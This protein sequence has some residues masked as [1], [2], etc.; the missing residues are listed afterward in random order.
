MPRLTE[1]K[2][3][4]TTASARHRGIDTGSLFQC[5]PVLIDDLQARGMDERLYDTYMG[6]GKCVVKDNEGKIG[7]IYDGQVTHDLTASGFSAEWRGN[8]RNK[9]WEI[10]TFERLIDKV[11]VG[12]NLEVLQKRE[13]F[14]VCKRATVD[15]AFVLMHLQK[16]A[17]YLRFP[18]NLVFRVHGV[19]GF[20]NETL[21]LISKCFKEAARVMAERY[22]NNP[23]KKPKFLIAITN[24]VRWGSILFKLFVEAPLRPFLNAADA[25]LAPIG[26][27][28]KNLRR[29]NDELGAA[30][31]FAVEN[32][33]ALYIKP[34][35]L[36]GGGRGVMRIEFRSADGTAM[37]GIQTN[38]EKLLGD[39][40]M[41]FRGTR[42]EN[43]AVLVNVEGENAPEAYE[44]VLR[45]ILE[46]P[47]AKNTTDGRIMTGLVAEEE[48]SLQKIRVNGEKVPI[49]IRAV[50]V[51]EVVD[52]QNE[53]TVIADYC[54]VGSNSVTAN[55]GQGGTGAN[56]V[57]VL[58]ELFPDK[59][60]YEIIKMCRQIREIA[61]TAVMVLGT[62]LGKI[63]KAWQHPLLTDIPLLGSVDIGIGRAPDGG[64]R[65]YVIE[66]NTVHVGLKGLEETDPKTYSKVVEK[67]QL[68]VE[69][70]IKQQD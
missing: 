48:M 3:V 28:F 47:Y 35:I 51:R 27:I 65:T 39:I 55:I 23:L 6:Q 37:I 14:L 64:I 58:S 36:S 18:F 11:F 67:Y 34:N 13:V 70:W 2:V 49:E 25:A 26:S 21:T 59:G 24:T 40:E 42:T 16:A 12:A 38:D 56:T 30:I 52:D 7:W 62:E 54:K 10:G 53:V 43:G 68:A 29:S 19:R 46:G 60:P 33:R 31:R 20:I 45:A 50:F 32:Q 4:M 41:K 61:V 66:F 9:Y 1:K 8:L 44:R 69:N 17:G 5:T 63:G 57:D 22:T 15:A